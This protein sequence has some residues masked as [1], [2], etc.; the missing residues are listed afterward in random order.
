MHIE[1]WCENLKGR[2]HLACIIVDVRITLK[3]MLKKE[4]GRVRTRFIRLR[5]GSNGGML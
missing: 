4:D 2:R 3:W 1:L 5:K